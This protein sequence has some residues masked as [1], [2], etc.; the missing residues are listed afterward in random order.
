M[1]YEAP[2]VPGQEKEP[3]QR[4]AQQLYIWFI[5]MHQAERNWIKRKA[6][7]N[8]KRTV[9]EKNKEKSHPGG[10]LYFG[11]K[12]QQ[13]WRMADHNRSNDVSTKPLLG[14]LDTNHHVSH[15]CMKKALLR[16][17]YLVTCSLY[18]L[19][20]SSRA[21]WCSSSADLSKLIIYKS[22]SER[23]II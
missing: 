2:E 9:N 1:L 4:V 18:L 15:V 14:A 20:M 22:R 8:Y 12:N 7:E 16:G 23:I 5:W 11:L 6:K 19:I 21:D 10:S 3:V 17:T 13:E